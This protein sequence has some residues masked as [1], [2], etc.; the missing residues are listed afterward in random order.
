M[1]LNGIERLGD[2]AD[3]LNDR[4]EEQQVLYEDFLIRVTSFFRDP[5]VFEILKSTVFPGIVRNCGSGNPIRIWVTGCSTGEEVYS[6]A[7]VL[8]EILGD[9]AANTPVKILATDVNEVSLEKARAGKYIDNISL[10]VSSDQL[11][12]FFSKVNSHYQICKSIRDLCVF[13]RHDVTRDTPFANLDLISCRNLLIYFDSPLQNRVIPYFHYALKPAACLMLGT[14]ETLGTFADRFDVLD[15]DTRVYSKKLNSTRLSLEFPV[16]DPG[17]VS[18]RPN[19]P[20]VDDGDTRWPTLQQ[21]IDRA[22][23][24]RLAFRTMVVDENF[25]ILHFRGNVAPFLNPESGTASLDLLKIVR[26]GLGVEIYAANNSVRR[27]QKSI[28][29]DD[30]RFRDA[31]N[32]RTVNFEVLPI[33]QTGIGRHLFLVI[34]DELPPLCAAD[35][36]EKRDQVLPVGDGAETT[37]R[38]PQL[39]HQLEAVQDYLQSVIEENET[40]QE[41]VSG[42]S[43][44]R[45]DPGQDPGRTPCRHD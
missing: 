21:E 37:I 43:R 32:L 31:D 36:S 27:D 10:D 12:R 20:G 9:M 5:A 3:W 8:M 35:E 17:F 29:R 40:A 44:N 45:L 7:I 23:L 24:G 11:Q 4:P 39:E 34:F 25:T 6:I 26:T 16:S 22:L 15:R 30:I 28:K 33:P 42:R 19:R 41:E 14:S 2:Y 13:P 18:R 38:V 1:G